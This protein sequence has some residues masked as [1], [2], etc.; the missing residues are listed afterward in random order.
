[1]NRLPSYSPNV[2]YPTHSSDDLTGKLG[3]YGQT[4]RSYLLENHAELYRQWQKAGYLNEYLLSLDLRY[5]TWKT[6]M[7][8]H[9]NER[10]TLLN[11]AQRAYRIQSEAD[12]FVLTLL[13]E[14]LR[15][16]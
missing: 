1:M 12:T 2:Y 9:M 7:V 6:K 13:Y 4:A 14:E 15:S 11:T 10:I 16:L 3:K 5:E 8:H